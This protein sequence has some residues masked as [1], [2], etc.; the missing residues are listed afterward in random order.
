MSAEQNAEGRKIDDAGLV[1]DKHEFDYVELQT[2]DVSR[3]CTS[4]CPRLDLS[5]HRRS[6]APGREAGALSPSNNIVSRRLLTSRLSLQLIR[7][8]SHLDTFSVPYRLF[9]TPFP[10][11]PSSSAMARAPTA[12]RHARLAAS[13]TLAAS[14]SLVAAAPADNTIEIVG[15]SGVR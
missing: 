13:L 14:L 1:V 6:A 5:K 3:S 15:D 4:F 9:F 2:E 7:R 11:V 10:P 8:A 12:R